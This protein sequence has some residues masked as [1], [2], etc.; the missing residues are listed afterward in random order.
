MAAISPPAVSAA[1]TTV[2]RAP[3]GR[4][5]RETLDGLDD[6]ELLGIVG[7]LAAAGESRVAAC[8][9]LVSR[10]R[11]L[12]RSCVQRYRASLEPAED[13]MQVGYVGLMK[14]IS[15]FDPVVGGN[16]AAY[17]QVCIS[18]EIK[19]YFRD[20]CWPVHVRR[21]TQDLVLEARKAASQLTQ[22]LG[23]A[24]TQSEMA[25][26]LEVS[27]EDL[28]DAQR[29]ELALRPSSLDAPV[30]GLSGQITIADLLGEEDRGVEHMLGMRAVAAHWGEL[31]PR[32]QK[33]LRMRFA[34]DMTQ[35][36]IGQHLGISQ[37]HVSRLSAQALGYLRQRVLGQPG[38]L[39]GAR[40]AATL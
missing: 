36:Q 29:A 39:P 6:R 13:L 14:A 11:S 27:G 4:V 15:R 1:A 32:E 28:R 2:P 20:K 30:T 35:A 16:L 24:P 12:V 31:A 25:R 3:A 18:G 22:D 9:L 21:S 37:M 33:I 17:A 10:H 7:S 34:D 40:P 5:L 26:H 38:H 8:E 23:R 19:R